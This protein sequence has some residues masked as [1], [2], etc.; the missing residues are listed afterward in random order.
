LLGS[1]AIA[2][3]GPQLAGRLVAAYGTD[4]LTVIA[5]APD[6]LEEIMGIG[7]TKAAQIHAAWL[8][9]ASW[10][11]LLRKLGRMGVRASL[12]A[13]LFGLYGD[14]AVR[15]IREAPYRILAEM[16]EIG[17]EAVD[18]MA[19]CS[20]SSVDPLQRGR[21][22]IRHLFYR[23]MSDGHT[24]IEEA[25]LLAECDTRY[26]IDYHGARDCLD[27]LV[28]TGEA[29]VENAAE[30][31]F[32][33]P[34]RLYHAE[35][36]IARRLT[37]MLTLSHDPEP[38]DGDQLSG[39]VRQS[40][41]LDLSEN[42]LK[43]LEQLMAHRVAVVS[44]GPGTGK[45]TLIKSIYSIFEHRSKSVVLAAPTGRAARRLSQVT[46]RA[47]HTL[48]RLLE[49]QPGHEAFFRDRDRPL[50]AQVVIVDEVSMVDVE[51]MHALLSAV[52]L[53]AMLILVGDAGQLPSVGPGNVLADLI[54]SEK[55]P[56]YY[57]TDMFRQEK[58]G[59]IA[60]NAHRVRQGKLPLTPEGGGEEPAEYVYVEH[61]HSQQVLDEMISWCRQ[62]IPSRYGL[63]PVGDT[64]VLTPMHK[65]LVGTVHLNQVL[66]SVLNP[67]AEGITLAGQSFKMG[68]KVMHLVNNYRK[69][70]FNGDIGVI[71]DIEPDK[72]VIGVDYEGRRVP[73]EAAEVHEL[74]SAYAISIHK[75]QGSEYP[76]V[77]IPLVTQH[78]ALLQRNVL[79]TALT[80]ARRLVVLIGS[81]RAVAMAVGRDQPSRRLTWLAERLREQGR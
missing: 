44:G 28:R 27:H 5:E 52:S 77:I 50:K 43:T 42:Q 59:L 21:A 56:V 12:A 10:R 51:L 75:S 20:G 68:D 49:Y 3:I 40:L 38:L 79:Y 61:D 53:Q 57:L 69:E 66:Q 72:N 62:K 54:R 29:F 65:G 32:V 23:R 36:G 73:Y 70:V 4:T 41:S 25:A 17:F 9:H 74:S 8:E 78:H 13:P 60:V 37:A 76:A 63:D 34:A 46:G 47:A 26:G 55:V 7:E 64:Q 30:G 31:K 22:A 45:T 2:G 11:R 80:R 18:Q 33:S 16:P 35:M 81:R 67:D 19:R 24:C 15:V 6:R 48:H 14:D 71:C 58:E 39:L 1:G